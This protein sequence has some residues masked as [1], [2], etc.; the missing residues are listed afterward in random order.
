MK[1][2]FSKKL[3]QGSVAALAI[4]AGI[5]V[6]AVFNPVHTATA[7]TSGC[8]DYA[9][10]RCG[11]NS[12]AQFVNKA[13]A[14]APG[15]LK[16]IFSDYG[17]QPSEYQRF[18]NLAVNGRIHNDGRIIVNGDVVGHST[19]NVG[20]VRDANFNQKVTIKGKDYWGG[21]FGSTYHANQADVMVLFNQKGVMEFAAIS[22][23]G[24]P[25]RF[26]AVKP[27]YSCDKLKR[28]AVDNKENTYDF[29]TNATAVKGAK[30]VKVVYDFGDGS[31]KVTRQDPNATVRHKFTKTSTVRVTVHVSLPGDNT[32][33]VTSVDC[34]RQITVSPPPPPPPPPVPTGTGICTNLT[35]TVVNSDRRSYLFTATSRVDAGVTLTG[36]DFTFGDGQVANGVAPQGTQVAT[37]HTYA[38]DGSYTIT[39]TL[40]FTRTADNV[41]SNS[42]CRTI[43]TLAPPVVPVGSGICT[44]LTATLLNKD[45]RSYRF[46]ATSKADAGV[47]FTGADFTFGDGQVVRNVMPNGTQA[48]VTHNYA[49]NDAR[50]IT[51]TLYFTRASDNAHTSSNCE[52]ALTPNATEYCLP[53]IPVGSPECTP[54]PTTPVEPVVLTKTGPNAVVAVFLSAGM[55]AGLGH[56]YFRR[57]FDG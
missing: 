45:Q 41:V 10:M 1:V 12:P 11:A 46:T 50:T 35:P 28:Q 48:I 9:I 25:Q 51:A 24:N 55:V 40:H 17:L 20:R 18:A 30:I 15:D 22:S 6:A 36:A 42:S 26:T 27:D 19:Q 56:L 34:T 21:P 52:V 43:L 7:D 54:A 29:S 39:A 57:R 53:G 13:R 4:T 23:C 32:D 44:G 47:T 14:N 8:D 5:A 2:F 38:Q 16:D 37:N 49:N 3:L 31:D 33:T